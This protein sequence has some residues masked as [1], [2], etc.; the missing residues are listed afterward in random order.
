MTHD[1]PPLL[2][3]ALDLAH[4]GLPVLPLRE[5]RPPANCPE[6]RDTA[7]GGRPHMRVPG[8][9][10]CPLPCHAW[11]AAT[12]DPDTLTSPQWAADWRHATSVAYHPGG[13]GLTVVDLDNPAAVTWA[14]R[15]LP[16]T[17]TVVTTRGEHWIYRG[18]TR[19]ANGV[20]A[21]V[22]IKSL[23]QYARWRGPGH[24]TM[25]ALPDVVRGLAVREETTPARGPVE[26]PSRAVWEAPAATGCRHTARYIRTG[27]E[28]GLA[29][30]RACTETG[31]GSK[32]FGVA[33]FLAAQHSRCP[34]P[35]GL[36]VIAAQV[37]AA[38]VSV[39]VP[40]GYAQRA[41][42]NGLAVPGVAV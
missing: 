24:G 41:V 33:R 18:T 22:D 39:G 17:R 9:C 32:A 28:K 13:A 25:T 2:Q 19:S 36:D 42:S 4:R 26:L 35:C 40:H 10:R 38:A 21:A 31:A 23:M 34:G 8:P 16:T 30:V 5:K 6:C 27:L 1:R 7:C 37:V 15:A 12:T 29:M 11:A 14:R 3:V 20:R